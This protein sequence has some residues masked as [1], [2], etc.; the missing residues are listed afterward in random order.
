MATATQANDRAEDHEGHR[1]QRYLDQ[2]LDGPLDRRRPQQAVARREEDAVV[3]DI[4]QWHE[5]EDDCVDRP[6][7]VGGQRGDRGPVPGRPWTSSDARSPVSSTALAA[8][9]VTGDW[10][11]RSPCV[12]DPPRTPLEPAQ[13]HADPPFSTAP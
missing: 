2:P 10:R 5:V 6:L 13:R 12:M 3:G 1:G 8:S 9:A 11:A 4:G 7:R